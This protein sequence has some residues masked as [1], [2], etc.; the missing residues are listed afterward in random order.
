MSKYS[1][2]QK[3]E[4]KGKKVLKKSAVE[5]IKVLLKKKNKQKARIWS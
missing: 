2:Y 4:K 5:D 3:K 1:C